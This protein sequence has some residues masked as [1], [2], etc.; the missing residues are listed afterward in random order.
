MSLANSMNV[1]GHIV[2]DTDVWTATAFPLQTDKKNNEPAAAAKHLVSVFKT[3][4]NAVSAHFK[5]YNNV[6]ETFSETS[7]A[8]V[9]WKNE[10]D[11]PGIE[12]YEN[13][14]MTTDK[15]SFDGTNYQAYHIM[16][17]NQ[18]RI[19]NWISPVAVIDP[20]TGDPVA[21][22]SG[23]AM[24]NNKELQAWN[25]SDISNRNWKLT[26]GNWEFVY[27][28]GLLIFE[29]SNTPP[30]TSKV[31][32]TAFRYN[33]R[34]VQKELSELDT[35]ISNSREMFQATAFISG[36]VIST[37]VL[38][39]TISGAIY[40][41]ADFVNNPVLSGLPGG[42]VIISGFPAEVLAVKEIR[43]KKSEEIYPDIDYTAK[44]NGVQE[45][46]T[47]SAE[48]ATA[49]EVANSGI[50]WQLTFRM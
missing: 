36:G 41:Q 34:T 39:Q 22:Y 1:D 5:Y 17:E 12:L 37:A 11:F 46:T 48:Y 15:T 4:S 23:L 7:G 2:R 24:Y 33:G 49:D 21:G 45:S 40:Q 3:N 32:L 9:V 35:A 29:P 25:A 47:L 26:A 19:K 44:A 16:D 38:G 18:K 50:Q 28:A 27:N 6:S 31:T 8:A 43:G 20:A 13:I 10:K 30:N 42:S 14:P